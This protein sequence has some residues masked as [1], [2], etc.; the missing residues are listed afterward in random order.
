MSVIPFSREEQEERKT[1]AALYRRMA[2][3]MADKTM[4]DRFFHLANALEDLRVQTEDVS[5]SASAWPLSPAEGW[6]AL[7]K[8]LRM[9]ADRQIAIDPVRS[10]LLNE[11]ARQRQGESGSSSG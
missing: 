11:S 8:T 1:R 7:S 5:P 9:E 4:A 6:Q 3:S 2:Q 10:A